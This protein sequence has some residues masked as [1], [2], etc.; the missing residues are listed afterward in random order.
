MKLKS[1]I[2]VAFSLLLF[3]ACTDLSET[4]YD[5]VDSSDYGKTPA[6]IETIV[7]GVYSSLRGGASDG[8]NFFP[9][10]EFVFFVGA[11]SSD[12]CV[13]PTRVGGDWYDD[14]VY[15]EL[16]KHT[17]TANNPKIWAPWKYCYNGVA[18]ANAVI[19]Q[20][21][22][23]GLNP[24]SS[25]PL[26]AELKA[27]RAYYYY[28]LLDYY[29]NVPIDTSYVVTEPPKTASRADVYK[30]VE[31]ELINNI[32]YL[33]EN[34]YGRFTKDAA[35]LLLARLYLN[36]EVYIGQ[37]RWQDCINVCGKIGGVLEADYFKSFSTD[38]HTSKEIIF[39]IPYDSKV[40][41]SGNYLA[42]MTYHYEQKYAFSATGNYQWCGNGIS[43]QPGLY[44]AFEETDMRRNSI[45]MGPQINLST[46]SVI[47]MPASGNPLIYTEE[48]EDITKAL[49]NEG[50][51]LSKYEDKEGDNWSRDYDMVLMRYAEV[52]MMQ[53]ECYVR[54]GNPAAARSFVEQIRSRVGLST[55]ENITL[56]FI[57]EELRREFVFEDHR[58]TDNIRFGTFFKAWWEKDADA[59]KHTGIFPIPAKEMEKNSKLVQNPG[60][61]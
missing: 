18:A 4:L 36:S 33:P 14:G 8:V 34:A 48:I 44:S 60:Y 41:N 21:E 32:D 57:D 24:E 31:K 28:K 6:E 47:I 53:A 51:R 45:M 25:R 37:P 30:F 16:Q 59:D 2:S 55:P 61:N 26:F 39:S 40:T 11:I 56:E 3:S 49:Q 7:G 19:Y 29:G 38:N 27:L 22:Q 50:G 9:T 1:I 20:V 43:A 12:E 46:G 10:D 15:I 58:R 5:K 17:W 13:I 35:N 54:L 42:S 52:L 23:S